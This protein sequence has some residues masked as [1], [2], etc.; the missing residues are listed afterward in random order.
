MRGKPSGS[1]LPRIYWGGQALSLG[2]LPD[3][4]RSTLGW[5]A[6]YLRRQEIFAWETGQPGLR[7][8][9][10]LIDEVAAHLHPKWQRHILPAMREAFPEV[11]I[12]VTTHSPFV[13]ASSREARVHVLEVDLNR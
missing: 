4:V 12:I 7:K 6:D 3:G 10:L 5:I 8:S 9:I 11:Q 1:F 2:Q 13:I